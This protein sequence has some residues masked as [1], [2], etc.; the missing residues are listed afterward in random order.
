MVDWKGVGKIELCTC[1]ITN[2]QMG[3]SH[4]L[5]S[6]TTCAQLNLANPFPIHH[7]GMILQWTFQVS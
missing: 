6:D 4:L 7:G 1:R 5:V 2:Y 3:V